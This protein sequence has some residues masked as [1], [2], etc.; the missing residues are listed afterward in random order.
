MTQITLVFGDISGDGHEK[1]DT[2]TIETN[3]SYS[4]L[5]DAIYKSN[6][7]IDSECSDYDERTLSEELT[8]FLVEIGLLKREDLN[9]DYR[10]TVRGDEYV[11]RL[12]DVV[13]Y[14]NPDF[15]WKETALAT[16]DVGGYGLFY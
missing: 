2:L 3:Y 7:K 8:N 14:E 4:K 12:L 16:M 11:R 9:G 5:R 1:T 13:K 6:F 15:Q 10:L